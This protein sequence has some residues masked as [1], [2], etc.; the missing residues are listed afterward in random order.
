MYVRFDVGVADGEGR[1]AIP[2]ALGSFRV[3]REIATRPLAI[4][5]SHYSSMCRPF[6]SFL[7]RG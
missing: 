2:D 4:R 3:A 1:V 7:A 5:R 6:Q